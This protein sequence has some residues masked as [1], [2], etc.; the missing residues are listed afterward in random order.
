MAKTR[1]VSMELALAFECLRMP[2]ALKAR[3]TELLGKLHSIG[4]LS[5]KER[6]E[7]EALAE[8]NDSLTLLR[9]EAMVAKKRKSP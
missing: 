7:A 6:E 5:K 2:E 3:L 9:A 8:L 4:K 1:L